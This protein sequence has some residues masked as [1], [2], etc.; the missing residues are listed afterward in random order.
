MAYHPQ[1]EMIQHSVILM[2]N[3]LKHNT[4]A[5]RLFQSK[6]FIIPSG[7]T[8]NMT[9]IQCSSEGAVSPYKN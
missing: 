6:P 4:I 3:H 7:E 8:K 5:V 2:S 9:N 1:N